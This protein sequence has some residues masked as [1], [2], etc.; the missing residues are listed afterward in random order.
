MCPVGVEAELGV[1]GGVGGQL[2][3]LIYSGAA[4]CTRPPL[5]SVSASLFIGPRERSMSS[6]ALHA[7]DFTGCGGRVKVTPPE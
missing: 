5:L 3:A 1:G 2:S 4:V 6:E 7:A